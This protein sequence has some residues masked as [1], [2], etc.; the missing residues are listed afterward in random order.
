MNHENSKA[1]DDTARMHQYWAVGFFDV[2]GQ[3]KAMRDIDF[4]PDE[5]DPAQME[6]FVAGVKRVYGAVQFIQESI[7]K[8]TRLPDKTEPQYLKLT[9]EQMNE[10]RKTIG[11][12]LKCQRFSDGLMVF[13]SLR[14]WQD[15]SPVASIF[16]LMAGSASIML[17][18]LAAHI[19]IRAGLDVGTGMEM[20]PGELYGPVVA[21]AYNLEN[22]VAQYPRVVLGGH[23]INYLQVTKESKETGP[24]M[25]FDKVMA[26][27]CLDML[28]VDV[29]G[30]PIV[31]YL[32]D[33]FRRH[34]GN[35]LNPELISRAH[36]YVVQQLG[37][38]RQNRDTKIA[39]RYSQLLNYFEAKT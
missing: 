28:T 39:F 9:A 17:G 4:I 16:A 23:I 2:L 26:S 6:E 20:A 12:K 10:W 24:K 19:P 32:G 30:W 33:G 5:T 15:H 14:D 29:D 3:Q 35:G 18:S 38:A 25:E 1:C 13:L 27:V 36:E 21:C 31:D 8:W 7:E 37:V 11:T 34:M 22:K